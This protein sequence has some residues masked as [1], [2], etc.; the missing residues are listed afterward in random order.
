MFRAG[1]LELNVHGARFSSDPSVAP[2]FKMNCLSKRKKDITFEKPRETFVSPWA[3]SL[4]VLARSTVTF[5][6]VLSLSPQ[7]VP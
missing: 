2:G 5:V 4:V 1:L 3:Y 7:V 6:P